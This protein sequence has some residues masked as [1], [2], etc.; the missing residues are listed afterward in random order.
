MGDLTANLSAAEFA[1]R[2][3]YPDCHHKKVAHMPLVLAI[4]DA[5]D[6]FKAKYKASAVSVQITGPNRCPRHNGETE[7]AAANSPHVDCIAADHKIRVVVGGLPVSVP[8]K[9]LY[10]Y[11]DT[12]YF[13]RYGVGLYANRVHLDTRGEKARWDKTK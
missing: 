11:Y 6:H 10:T 5:A 8:P 13:D 1:C 9:E 7:G 12:K 2:C 4:Q 3:N